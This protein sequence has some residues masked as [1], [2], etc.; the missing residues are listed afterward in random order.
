MENSV[1]RSRSAFRAW[2][3]ERRLTHADIAKTLGCRVAAVGGWERGTQLSGSW[4]IVRR[5]AECYEM[6]P[7]EASKLLWNKA[8]GDPNPSG[9]SNSSDR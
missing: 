4:G 1:D 7:S 8:H 2:R 3:L 9:P 6:D 5:F